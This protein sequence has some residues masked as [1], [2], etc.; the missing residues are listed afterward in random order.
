MNAT[1]N[2]DK[3]GTAGMFITAIFSP[4]CFPLFA[5]AA[6]ALG[7][8]SFELFG[9]KTMWVFQAMLLVSL[10][11]LYISYRKHRCLYPLLLA[12]ASALS[13]LYGCHF[14]ESDNWT[15]FLYAGMAGLLVGSI[16]NYNRNKMKGS[17]DGCIV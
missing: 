1:Q 9:E 12:S 8:G 3:V 13:I 17:C 15:Y 5:F 16:W 10:L 11:G 7:L 14:N 4:C 6:S 2:I